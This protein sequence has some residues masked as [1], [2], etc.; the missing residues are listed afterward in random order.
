M[1]EHANP[2]PLYHPGSICE[3]IACEIGKLRRKVPD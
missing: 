1:V 3:S 2:V